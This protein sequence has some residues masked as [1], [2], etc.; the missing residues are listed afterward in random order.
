[1]KYAYPKYVTFNQNL[2]TL[3][4]KWDETDPVDEW[5][6][7]RADKIQKIQGN[8]N[9]ILYQRCQN[10]DKLKVSNSNPVEIQNNTIIYKN[11]IQSDDLINKN[12]VIQ[13]N[14]SISNKRSFKGKGSID[15][16]K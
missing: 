2:K 1:M 11:N 15:A 9:Q 3:I 7:F 8:L 13:Q 4:K 6:C 14:S 5:E 10:Q 12:N 16:F